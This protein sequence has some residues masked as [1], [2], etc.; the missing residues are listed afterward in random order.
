VEAL[1]SIAIFAVGLASLMPLVVA[2]VRAN[3]AASVRSQAVAVCQAK[4]E[5]FRSLTYSEVQ[6]YS[7]QNGTETVDDQ[8]GVIGPRIFTREWWIDVGPGPPADNED[9]R[10]I[11]VEVRWD[12]P[13]RPEGSVALITAR[14]RY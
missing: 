10:R 14:A 2:N 1:V 4:I 12:L 8:G 13:G 5:E 6:G 9:L 7:P 11:K 3:D